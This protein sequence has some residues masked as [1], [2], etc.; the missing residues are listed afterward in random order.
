MKKTD[1]E[2]QRKEQKCSHELT[3]AEEYIHQL[4]SGERPNDYGHG[5]P[6]CRNFEIDYMSP[7]YQQIEHEH[8]MEDLERVGQ[9]VD[10]M[11]EEKQDEELVARRRTEEDIDKFPLTSTDIDDSAN[12]GGE[13]PDLSKVKNWGPKREK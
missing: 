2:R 7:E 12:Y 6:N 10:E 9:I 5:D 8:I 13:Y 1:Y 4:E 3:H 11:I